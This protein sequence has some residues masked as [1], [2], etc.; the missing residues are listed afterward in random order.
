M[1]NIVRSTPTCGE[2]DNAQLMLRTKS[3]TPLPHTMRTCSEAAAHG[4]R[5]LAQRTVNLVINVW[6][7]KTWNISY[8]TKK[9][10]PHLPAPMTPTLITLMDNAPLALPPSALETL[11]ETLDTEEELGSCCNPLGKRAFEGIGARFD[12][13][14]RS[15]LIREIE[16]LTNPSVLVAS[17]RPKTT[18]VAA[19]MAPFCVG[20]LPRE[21]RGQ[22]PIPRGANERKL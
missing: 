18:P 3:S 14:C 6:N 13:A 12:S 19:V 20:R 16:G 21:L 8:S 9:K 10:R 22:E 1:F 7:C 15:G 11:Q 17:K 4:T 5:A 2:S